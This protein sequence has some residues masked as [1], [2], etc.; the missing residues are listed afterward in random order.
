MAEISPKTYR[1]LQDVPTSLTRLEKCSRQLRVGCR[2][3]VTGAERIKWVVAK[4]GGNRK[5]FKYENF[6]LEGI[7]K[8]GPVCFLLLAVAFQK[9]EV[10]NTPK[11][12]LEDLLDE[13]SKAE[14]K[15]LFASELWALAKEHSIPGTQENRS[16]QSIQTSGRD[17]DF[18]PFPP[19]SKSPFRTV[20]FASVKGTSQ[21]FADLVKVRHTT[22]NNQEM[23]VVRMFF[24]WW[25]AGGHCYMS[26]EVLNIEELV[27]STFGIS[28]ERKEQ[29]FRATLENGST[30]LI[31]SPKDFLLDSAKIEVVSKFFRPAISNYYQSEVEGTNT[32]DNVLIHLVDGR[33]FVNIT[34]RASIGLMISKILYT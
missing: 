7:K 29:W 15:H 32:T 16:I 1:R 13:I 25:L 34:L 22:Y 23:S 5:D 3:S 19:Q 10:T 20:E 21:V 24:P 9:E 18:L 28:I 6:L 17:Q 33:G 8:V 26:L 14:H 30:V 12:L 2:L 31:P 27:L 11:S 4:K